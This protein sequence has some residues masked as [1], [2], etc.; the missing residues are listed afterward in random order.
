MVSVMAFPHLVLRGSIS[1]FATGAGQK[2]VQ[3]GDC[4]AG[5]GKKP[6][7]DACRIQGFWL[8]ALSQRPLQ[9]MGCRHSGSFVPS[10]ELNPKP[11]TPKNT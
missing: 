5:A 8:R 7:Q 1:G 2:V 11:L 3:D 10:L 4:V 9:G 6:S